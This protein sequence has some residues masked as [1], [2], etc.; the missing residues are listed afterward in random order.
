M[1]APGPAALLLAWLLLCTRSSPHVPAPWPRAAQKLS[2]A[3]M[4]L[5]SLEGLP[6]SLTNLS[7]NDNNI[8]GGRGRVLRADQMRPA[9]GRPAGLRAALGVFGRA[10]FHCS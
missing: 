6:P 9:R 4:G 2:L 10:L 3:S 7:V 5:K 8:T 1:H